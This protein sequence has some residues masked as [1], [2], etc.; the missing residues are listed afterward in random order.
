MLGQLR[1]EKAL[2]LQDEPK[3][4]ESPSD[5]KSQR[6][7]EI[8]VDMLELGDRILIRPGSIP[9]A[10]GIVI[11]GS[12]T[13][14]ESSLTGESVPVL[15]EKG[16]AVLTGT[17]VLSS[18]IVVR[19]NHL[20]DETMLQQ[21]VRA[22]GESQNSKA[23]IEELADRVTAI[24]VP[25]IIYLSVIVLVIWLALSLTP[26]SRG[27]IPLSYLADGHCLTADRIF[28][29]FEF[30]IA[31]L[32]VACP[33]G[34]GLAAP[35]AQA[36]GSG[37]AA[38][39]GILAQ[40]G[41]TAFQLATQVDTV[42]FDKTGTLTMGMPVVVRSRFFP[43]PGSKC[44]LSSS[45]SGD[46]RF[47]TG[48]GDQNVVEKDGEGEDKSWTLEAVRLIEQNSSHPLAAA[49]VRYVEAQQTLQ[50]PASEEKENEDAEE[51]RQSKTPA[52][53]ST[54]VSPQSTVKLVQTEEIAGK[55]AQGQLEIEGR[56]FTFCLGNAAL[57][58]DN[59]TYSTCPGIEK[60][61]TDDGE[62]EKVINSDQKSKYQQEIKNWKT[63]GFSVVFF[64][65]S[66]LS[67][68]SSS[69]TSLTQNGVA[70]PIERNSTSSTNTSDSTDSTP[71]SSSA[72]T[73][74]LPCLPVPTKSMSIIAQFAIADPPRPEAKRVISALKKAGKEVY[75][76][77]GD[78][79]T[80]AR[81]VGSELGI[82]D[83][84]VIAGV[85]PQQK[86]RFIQLL[87]DPQ[88]FQDHQDHLT[89][90][91][92]QGPQYSRDLQGLQGL[93]DSLNSQGACA[94]RDLRE[95]EVSKENTTMMWG[96]LGD[97][98]K[99]ENSENQKGKDIKKRKA[100]AV[101]MFAGDGLNDSA[102]V[103]GADVG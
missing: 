58:G 74:L 42:V 54:P 41:G 36:V 87:Q 98:G 63:Q 16:D 78:N 85:L 60:G 88:S 35:A 94:I 80:T 79:E 44:H 81:A 95:K 6:T 97:E 30:A 24:F 91:G 1:P 93:R 55:G 52:Q 13:V 68:S 25:F 4:P 82:D 56:A 3:T 57:M 31:L 40:G 50:T 102:A 20:G 99:T 49:L 66:P 75:M 18:A 61:F 19:V 47:E 32:A 90:R 17:T 59:V 5:T 8:S 83:H 21:I 33:C 43:F 65:I 100:K 15:K 67:P 71:F 96:N 64:A 9:P 14:D 76:L 28:F 26:E 84:R 23:P 53:P 51:N 34:I 101:V 7:E 62:R 29:A 48:G 22:V 69:S 89:F 77:S 10:D 12:T 45:D 39:A 37:M 70:E 38:R 27:G 73:T 86:A 46:K 103:A 2:L 11:E 72:S 92:L